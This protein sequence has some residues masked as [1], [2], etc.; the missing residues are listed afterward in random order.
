VDI[1]AA[2]PVGVMVDGMVDAM[3]DS[4]VVEGPADPLYSPY[5]GPGESG[6]VHVD[7]SL[8]PLLFALPER[9]H[10]TPIE[11]FPR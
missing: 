1:P 11:R 9:R 3:V 6:F 7:H 4:M 2:L 10:L 8:A 5:P